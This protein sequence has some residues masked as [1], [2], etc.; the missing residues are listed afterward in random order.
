MEQN[1]G[2]EDEEF[3]TELEP[4]STLEDEASESETDSILNSSRHYWAKGVKMPMFEGENPLGWVACV[5]FFAVQH[6]QQSAKVRLAFITMEENTL[7][8]FQYWRHK[9][10]RKSW[11]IFKAML[12]KV[13][14]WYR[15]GRYL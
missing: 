11:S 5:K 6:V 7:H 10:K 1:S 13:L 2:L 3:A 9:T 15:K 8:R 14:W 12:I 4:L